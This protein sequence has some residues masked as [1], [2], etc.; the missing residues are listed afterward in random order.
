MTRQ[1]RELERVDTRVL[2]ALRFVDAGT[3][4]DIVTPLTLRALEGSARFVRNRSGLHVIAQW[5][6]LAAHGAS[7]TEPPATPAV[8]SLPL[9]IAVRD[10][11]G[12]YLPRRVSVALPR[13]AD[14]AHAA[15]AGSLFRPLTVPLYAASASTTGANWSVLRATVR[16]A[17]TGD[18]LGGA[19]LR[20]RRNG[21]VMARGLTD[22]RGEALVPLVGVPRQTV[23]QDDQAVVV[24]EITV[25]V[26]AIFDPA[27]GTRL[28]A[29]ALA[30]GA[31][32]PVPEVDPDVLD[33]DNTLPHTAQ[34]LAVA[35]RRSQSLTLSISVP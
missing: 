25:S 10:E 33:A 22:G 17:A 8:A 3:G 18:A 13:D 30:A 2:G 19:L 35:A 34:S 32:P 1:I 16:E 28:P 11:T 31:R 5:S 29:A 6:A 27:S 4:T 9:P 20:V 21:T 12:R 15:D 14:P 24:D 26:E 23:G 7:F